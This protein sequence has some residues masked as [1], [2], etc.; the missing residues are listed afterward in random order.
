MS[1]AKLVGM[2]MLP[3]RVAPL[4][5]ERRVALLTSLS[6]AEPKGWEAIKTIQLGIAGVFQTGSIDYTTACD[7]S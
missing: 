1:V 5:I 3:R 4:H 2:A 7:A 6:F